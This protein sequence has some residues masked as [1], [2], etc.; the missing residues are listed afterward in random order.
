MTPYHYTE[1]G[2]TN[3][4][5]LNGIAIHRTP[6]GKATG[7]KDTD[8]LHRAI[9]ARLVHGKPHWSGSEFRFIREQ[10]DMSQASLAGIFGK[11]VQ[12]VARR[13]KSA[14]VTTMADRFLRAL[15]RE[16]ADGNATTVA[17]VDLLADMGRSEHRRMV[18]EERRGKWRAG[19]YPRLRNSRSAV[20]PRGA[21]YFSAKSARSDPLRDRIS[22]IRQPAPVGTKSSVTVCFS[23]KFVNATMPVAA[24]DVASRTSITRFAIVQSWASTNGS[25]LRRGGPPRFRASARSASMAAISGGAK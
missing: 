19:S 15:Y 16:H 9:A 17:M 14:R 7:V 8:G 5:L 22:A 1:S 12:S 24:V 23:P 13:E 20:D 21:T 6:Y 3:V 10:L 18:F 11:D 2:L 4:W 25:P